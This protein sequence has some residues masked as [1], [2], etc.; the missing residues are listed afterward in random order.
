M[1][2]SEPEYNAIANKY[3]EWCQEDLCMQ[4]MC[5]YSTL[6]ELEKEGVEGKT[7]LEVGCGPC[8]IGQRLASLGAKKIIGLD[9]SSGM[10]ESARK[11]LSEMKIVDKFDF[12]CSNILDDDFQL[13]E[14][15]DVVVVS[16]M[17]SACIDNYQTLA[18]FFSQ[19]IKLI[20]EG[21]FLHITDFSWV[22]IPKDGFWMGQYT[23][24][25][26]KDTDSP[27]EFEVFDFFINKAPDNPM[28]I[29]HIPKHLLF[30]AGSSAGFTQIK[31][32]PQYPDPEYKNHK[33]IRQY[34]DTCKP[35]DYIMKLK[36]VQP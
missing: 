26:T 24:F 16:Y 33:I 13:P 8:P 29:Y 11:N 12:V 22:R 4:K 31:T 27:K 30:K 35:D 15:V 5:Y 3:D 23:S 2:E 6:A 28:K 7:F 25:G 14:K 10:L 18:K 32:R 17:L 36:V 19:C 1:G 34:L 21:G 20:K 9:V